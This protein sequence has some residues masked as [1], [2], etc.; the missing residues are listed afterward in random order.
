MFAY[1]QTGTGKTYTMEGP[2][3]SGGL[4]T[5]AVEAVFAG[6]GGSG[7]KVFFQYTQLYNSQFTDL[8]DPAASKDALAVEEGKNFMFVRAAK[9]LPAG[10]KYAACT[11]PWFSSK[12]IDHLP[13]QAQDTH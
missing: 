1:G 13:R 12:E 9:I 8:L 2:G 5:Q 11:K 10:A 6:L 4:I 7:Q 3:G